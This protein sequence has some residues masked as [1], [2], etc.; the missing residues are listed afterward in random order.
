MFKELLK[1]NKALASKDDRP[2]YVGLVVVDRERHKIMLGKRREDNQ[3]TG[4]GGA[5][6]AHEN[7]K[8]AAI[9]EAYE[10]AN[11]QLKPKDLKELPTQITLDG[12]VCHCFLVYLDSKKNSVHAGN[13]PDREVAKWEWFDLQEP[14]PRNIGRLRLNTINNAKMKVLG[15]RKAIVSQ[16]DA[17]IDLNTAEQAQDVVATKD[18]YWVDIITNTMHGAEFGDI[19][20]ELMLPGH[21]MLVV[22]KVDDGVYSGFVK[23]DDPE[24]GDNGEILVQLQKMTP[25]AMVTA[26]RAKEYLP[27]AQS[28]TRQVEEP[29]DYAGLYDALKNFQGDLHIHLEKSTAN[30]PL[31]DLNLALQKVL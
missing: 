20:R 25:E 28:S 12:K 3:W 19:P 23:K 5:A 11:L 4:P 29:K 6:E 21:L 15:L 24:A 30:S 14:L 10:E 22:S 26:L 17:G 1:L 7:P 31:E 13:D 27:K 9:R 16:P 2:Y 8:Q 18:S